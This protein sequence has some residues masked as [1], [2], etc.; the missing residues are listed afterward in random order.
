MKRQTKNGAKGRGAKLLAGL[1][2]LSMVMGACSMDEMGTADYDHNQDQQPGAAAKLHEAESQLANHRVD[3]AQKLYEAHLDS[4]PGDGRAAVGV[5]ITTLL[6]ALEMEEVS[7]L[8]VEHLGASSGL[9]ANALLYA[10]GGYLYWKSRG[11]QWIDDG[12]S[13]QD[14]GV[15][16]LLE[17]ELPWDWDRM[18]SMAAFVDGL[19]EPANPLVRQMRSVATGLKDIDAYLEMAMD[20]GE[21]HRL[22]IPGEVFHDSGLA[23]QLGPAELSMLRAFIA[24]T[25]GAAYF[26]EAYDHEWTLE[27]A[28]GAWRHNVGLDHSSYVP[29]FG[30]ADYTVDYL[31][32]HLLREVTNPDRLAASRLALREGI[33]HLR[34]ALHLGV[35]Q[36]YS[37]T[38]AWEKLDGEEAFEMDQFLEAM[39]DALDGPTSLPHADG[40]TVDLSPLFEDG[41]R[42]LDKEIDWF[43]RH[44]PAEGLLD[45][46][47]TLEEV[48][49]H[50]TISEEALYAFFLDGIVD[51]LPQSDDEALTLLAGPH[52]GVTAFLEVLLGEYLQKVEGVYM[53]TR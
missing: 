12:Q 37:T 49:A 35:E 9:D 17:D 50:W 15:L 38:L 18:K 6:L 2:M 51:P 23:L 8:L 14:F 53:Q 40:V 42:R 32:G 7:E 30:A 11:A 20:D 16:T 4:Y 47:E 26:V 24:L 43:E 22:Y 5:G 44:S 36:S 48:S 45:A 52:G 21:F 13:G 46:S 28:F 29:G 31:D 41:G 10:E 3:E 34:Q 1:L 25:R 33:G 39:E 27:G 19:D